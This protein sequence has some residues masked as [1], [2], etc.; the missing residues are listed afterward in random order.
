[1]AAFA[2]GSGAEP[3]PTSLQKAVVLYVRAKNL[4]RGTRAEYLV[5]LRK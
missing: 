3:M 2:G 1:M 4:A 5:T